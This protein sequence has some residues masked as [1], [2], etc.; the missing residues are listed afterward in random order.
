MTGTL[1]AERYEVLALLGEG[2]M[3][4]VY[5]VRDRAGGG[6]V[7]LKVLAARAGAAPGSTA[8]AEKSV[9]QLRQEFQLMTR[10]RHP[11]CCAVY[12]YGTMPDGAPYF[13]MELVPGQ[14]LDELG[15]LDEA[16]FRDA[17][18]QLLRALAYVHQA[19]FVHRDVKA[20]NVRVMA[21]GRLVLMDYGLMIWA[22][23]AGLPIAGTLATMAPEVIKRGAVDGRAD[24]YGAGCLAYELLTGRAPFVR[25][26]PIAVMRA[27]VD[28][29]PEP[30]GRLRP[31]LDPA[32]TRVILRL[33]AKEPAERYPTAEAALADLGGAPPA[34]IGGALVAAPLVGREPELAALEARLAE[35]LAGRPGGV[36]ALH[37]PPGAGKSRL[38]AELRVRAQLAELP[39]AAAGPGPPPD[40][41]Y[42]A[43]VAVL[44]LLLPALR[45]R[46]PEALA[47]ATPALARLLPELAAGAAPGDD[48]D[49]AAGARAI[50][51]PIAA[52]AAHTPVVIVLD[53]W[54]WA[55]PLSRALLAELA[56]RVAA[57][58]VLIAL[59]ARDGP[60]PAALPAGATPL[61][62]PPLAGEAL[63]RM[64]RAMLGG[65]PP[66]AGLLDLVT[67]L[68]AGNPFHVERLLVH[69][70]RAGALVPGPGGWR[71]AADLDATRL[72]RNLD[73]L[74]TASF[75]ALSPA[76][77]ALA[78]AAAI[79]GEAVE[80]EVLG[81][82]ADLADE[83]LLS[84][85]EELAHA[86]IGAVGDDGRF[87]FEADRFLE[88]LY[89]GLP[90]EER[91][92]LHGRAATAVARR[93][94][95]PAGA[96]AA[97]WP[98]PALASAATHA[99]RA[100]D[101]ALALPLALE[102]G[103]RLLNLYAL[104]EAERFLMGG[105]ALARG[106]VEDQ[107]A[108]ALDYLKALWRVRYLD[109]RHDDA[110]A[111]AEEA[112]AIAEAV[113]NAAAAADVCL[114]LGQVAFFREDVA[115]AIAV[116]GDAL[117]RAAA[118]GDRARMARVHARRGRA[119]SFD[120]RTAAAIADLEAAC[121]L[122][123]P[124]A[125]PAW[126]GDVWS[127]LG[128][129]YVMHRPER[130][131]EGRALS[132]RAVATFRGL[133]DTWLI[134][135]ALSDYGDICAARGA[136]AEARA[137]FQEALELAD[138]N[139]FVYERFYTRVNRS[140]IALLEGDFRLA[141]RFAAEGVTGATAHGFAHPAA[142]CLAIGALADAG[143][144]RLAGVVAQADRALATAREAAMSYTALLV[145]GARVEVM[146]ALGLDAAAE[147]AAMEALALIPPG[148]YLE[149][150][151]MLRAWLAESRLR[152][153]DLV[154]ARAEQLACAHLAGRSG[155]AGALI[156][157]D[158]VGARLAIAGEAWAEARARAA[159]AF[160][161]AEACGF[162]PVAAEAA[163][164]L[165]EIALAVGEA[166]VA[167]GHFEAMAA[168]AAALP[169]P[170]L[171]ALARFGQAAAAPYAP[172]A[173]EHVAA[174]RGLL[175]AAVAR[176]DE[177][178]RAAW[179]A[180]PERR[181]AWAGNHVAFSLP[182]TSSRPPSPRLGFGMW[183]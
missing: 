111:A 146:E 57:L 54:Q 156:Q 66:P 148:A 98:L 64:I 77:R 60:E 125:D 128:L 33:L 159:A 175:E 132:A 92:A 83:A 68:A 52:L 110:H 2:A 48:P 109:R 147:A 143:A 108:A 13:T 105:L 61:P 144:G 27:H 151:A 107:R 85:R 168:I 29:P 131:E 91:A 126:G 7:A 38:A 25:A 120:G 103:R 89:G 104:E 4:R 152:R 135:H 154:G 145:L 95:D 19:G 80:L 101:T 76:A 150:E 179:L 41:P 94:G 36:V 84:A 67:A 73:A 134:A 10:L 136:L 56:S 157:A 58:P 40:V 6:E 86:R 124:E 46:A 139:G 130:A 79:T 8:G 22:G 161:R 18:T 32:L 50:A 47:T 123:D 174:A 177:A 133:G 15:R 65:V 129:L 43:F 167:A 97:S 87:V 116:S 163:G 44:R 1:L 140:W 180:V 88:T 12:D 118:L 158:R 164:L 137:A 138:A 31:D 5:R 9:L 74:L 30:I 149:Q 28:E 24:L 100:A 51:G 141:A 42:A 99:L 142:F 176:L 37:G 35:V 181:R 170:P 49:H 3:G 127:A 53:D 169:A 166:A 14:G 171:L 182:R 11:N 71:L 115:A 34:G 20:A 45:A 114:A 26:T 82:V 173:A 69:L 90:G 72:P 23:R 70:A 117:A 78:R 183:G 96:A 62:V 16:A 162:R 153:G 160:A 59:T 63:A 17:F 55:D 165:G 113:G 93:Q 178:T 21:D 119:H 172:A 102:A 122:I 81:A 121:A 112:L 155:A 106:A 75:A 39:V